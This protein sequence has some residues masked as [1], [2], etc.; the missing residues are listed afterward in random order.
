MLANYDTIRLEEW[1]TDKIKS[2]TPAKSKA[3]LLLILVERVKKLDNVVVK[4]T[5]FINDEDELVVVPG[6]WAIVKPAFSPVVATNINRNE[7]SFDDLDFDG[8]GESSPRPF[9][10]PSPLVN[11][12]RSASTTAGVHSRTVSTPTKYV[13][14][15]EFGHARIQQYMA[16]P[17]RERTY[18]KDSS[19]GSE[20]EDL[21]ETGGH[22]VLHPD[23]FHIC[24][25]KG[26]GIRHPLAGHY[27]PITGTQIPETTLLFRAPCTPQD[28]E[29][30]WDIV[31]S[32]YLFVT[33]TAQD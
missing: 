26:W 8:E 13:I 15:N 22:V 24:I 5:S 7:L 29:V 1:G 4:S 19:E 10:R 28:L 6:P 20:E 23:V 21:F 30:I 33:E 9:G 12:V 18:S 3:N 17:E 2:R 11:R 14:R 25:D 27:H 32:S 31:V 16:H